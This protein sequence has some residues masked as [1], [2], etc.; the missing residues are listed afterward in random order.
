MKYMRK[1]DK[2]KAQENIG[3]HSKETKAKDIIITK[4]LQIIVRNRMVSGKHKDPHPLV[5]K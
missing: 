3:N 5:D 1:L 2:I 4:K